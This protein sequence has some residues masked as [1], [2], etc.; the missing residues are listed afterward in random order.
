MKRWMEFMST[1]ISH[2]EHVFKGFIANSQALDVCSIHTDIHT[3][4][5]F[6]L[7]LSE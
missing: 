6:Q 1:D 5:L 7:E 3:Y 2:K 4:T